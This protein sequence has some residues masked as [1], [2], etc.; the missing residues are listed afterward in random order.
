[1]KAFFR[2]YFTMNKRERRGTLILTT[3]L[4]LVIAGWYVVPFFQP[5]WKSGFADFE[6]QVN[7]FTGGGGLESTLAAWGVEEEPKRFPFDPNGLPKEEWLRLGL[8]EKQASNI[9]NYEKAGGSFRKKEDLL[10][11]YSV[12]EAL[13]AQLEPWIQLEEH[14]GNS[15]HRK[16]PGEFQPATDSTRS[17]QNA[18]KTY[19]Y[20]E[21]F[22]DVNLADTSDW[23]RLYG[24]GP[25][26]AK[27]IMKYRDLLGGFVSTEQVREVYGLRDSTWMLIHSHLE[28]SPEGLEAVRKIDVNSADYKTLLKHPY[29][30]RNLANS[31]VMIRS[32]HGLYTRLE[33]LRKSDLVNEEIYRKIVPYITVKSPHGSGTH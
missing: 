19:D 1:M 22:I 18:Q 28:M 17:V 11:I 31:I 32:K 24:I 8:T 16:R 7:A 15:H 30:D 10:K 5:E 26:F 3:I 29:I 33:D 9:H 21:V 23:Q 4:F 12:D 6:E 14:S 27:R 25:V 13:Y 20:P 2:N